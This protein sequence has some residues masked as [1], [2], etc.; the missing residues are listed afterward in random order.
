MKNIFVEGIQGAGKSTLVNN[1]SKIVP[2]LRVCRE[3]D[4]S[5]ADLAWC[6]YLSEDEYEKILEKYKSISDEIIENTVKEE[7]KYIISYTKIITDIPGFHK[8]LENYEV[9]NGRKTFTE[10]KEII[11]TRFM[12]FKETGYLFEC[13]LFQNIIEDLMLFHMLGDEEI[14]AFYRELFNYIDAENYVL[15]YLYSDKLEENIKTIKKERCDDKGNELWYEVMLQYIS[16]SPYGKKYGCNGFDGLVN[17]LRHRQ[18]LELTIIKELMGKNAVVLS[19]KDY[20]FNKL[21]LEG[22]I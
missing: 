4:Y 19:S 17:H 8:D 16:C 9:Y 18:E 14:I 6:A 13:S 21:K 2:D 7:D 11:F 20:D 10:L 1:I 15:F 12:N 3:G 22:I 5:P